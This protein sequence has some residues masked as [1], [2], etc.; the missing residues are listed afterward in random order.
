MICL[1]VGASLW[2]AW[3][4]GIQEGIYQ[5]K[6]EAFEHGFMIPVSKEGG[7][8]DYEWANEELLKDMLPEN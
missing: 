7:W 6:R 8:I 1:G 3:S 2:A 5:M 4:E